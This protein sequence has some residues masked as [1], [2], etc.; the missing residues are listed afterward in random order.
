MGANPVARR[1]QPRRPQRLPAMARGRRQARA[2]GRHHSRRGR[3]AAVQARALPGRARLRVAVGSDALFLGAHPRRPQRR[4]PLLHRDNRADRGRRADGRVGVG[5]QVVADRGNPLGGADHQL[6]D[7]RRDVDFP[8]RA[9][10]RHA[11]DAGNYP[12]AGVGAVPLVP[13]RESVLLRRGDRALHLGAG[14]GQSHAVRSAGGRIRAGRRFRDRV[15]RDALSAFL[16][17]ASGATC[18]SPAR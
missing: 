12:G 13:V 4:Y 16:L 17:R 18:S 10:H 15:Q 8:G 9:D 1:P 11:L 6:R 5:Q 14:R 2:Q 3:C 7:S